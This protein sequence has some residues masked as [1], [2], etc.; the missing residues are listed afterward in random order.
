MGALIVAF[1]LREV[2]R[3]LF[4]PTQTG[5]L[6]DYVGRTVF[7]VFRHW[8]AG[9]S[10]AGPLSLVIVVLCWATLQALGFALIYWAG[11]PG[12]FE[13]LHPEEMQGVHTFWSLL[14]FSLQVMTT[15]GLGDIRP[16]TDWLRILVSV[17]ALT[18]LALVTASV[19][20]IVLLY[21]ALGRLR[22]LARRTAIL[23]AAS[24]ATGVDVMS[25]DVEY[26]IGDLALDVIRTRVDFLHFPI[27]YYFHSTRKDSSLAHTLPELARF[28]KRGAKAETGERVRLASAALQRALEDLARLMRRRFIHTA[29]DDPETVFR[30][31]AEDHRID[32]LKED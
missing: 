1:T 9:L 27:I 28:A 30:A 23:F 6:S 25:G 19:S 24:E 26:L 20:W 16:T 32:K 29:S 17:Q 31:Y 12:Q 3:D 10:N 11:F 21:P 8:P 5:S 4:H 7:R 18:G 14:Y 15:L 22:T 13:L 2:F